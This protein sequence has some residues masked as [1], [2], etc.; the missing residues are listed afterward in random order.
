MGKILRSCYSCLKQEFNLNNKFVRKKKKTLRTSTD[1]LWHHVWRRDVGLS[2]NSHLN[3]GPLVVATEP[4]IRQPAPRNI[5]QQLSSQ[6]LTQPPQPQVIFPTPECFS[7]TW[8]HGMDSILHLWHWNY[9]PI[10]GTSRPSPVQCS[11][12]EPGVPVPAIVAC[13]IGPISSPLTHHYVHCI[14]LFPY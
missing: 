1:Y 8:A 4:T 2:G 13:V 14:S 5:C 11:N 10:N 9:L 6:P 3:G 7:A 12:Q